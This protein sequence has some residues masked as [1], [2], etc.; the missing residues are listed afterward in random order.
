MKLSI[1]IPVYNVERYIR[2]C[3]ESVFLQG[4][5]D[6]DFEVII[7]ND[8]TKDQSIKMIAE[9]ISQHNN[10]TVINQENQGLS[11]ARN[12]GLSKAKGE[13]ILF[14]DSD[15]LLVPYSLKPIIEEAIKV[16]PTLVMANFIELN[17]E[18]INSRQT[19]PQ[20]GEPVF[21]KKTGVQIHTEDLNPH[22]CYVWRTLFRR[23]FLINNNITF[24][25]GMT[26]ED[27]VFTHTCLLY[28]TGLC[29]RTD[30]ILNIYRK[31]NISLSHGPITTKKA[32]D[33]SM[34]ISKIWELTYLQ[35]LSIEARKKMAEDTW[36]SFKTLIRLICNKPES[37]KGATKKMII[38]RNTAPHLFFRNSKK[39]IIV[40]YLYRFLPHI[41]IYLRYYYSI[42]IEEKVLPFYRHYL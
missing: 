7:V 14:I 33:F 1:I 11:I 36:V 25:P 41:L 26:F 12:N 5:N 20:K 27:I 16:S 35:G 10:I 32:E 34:A 28:A 21:I 13:Y 30:W 9:I 23:D 22:H 39:Q 8:G 40:S 42:I 4:L 19:Y 15:D 2:T 17:D 3:I 31:R 18:E 38:L 29:L 37:I 6:Q 24:I